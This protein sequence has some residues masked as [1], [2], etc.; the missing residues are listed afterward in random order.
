V[1]VWF[2]SPPQVD[3]SSELFQGLSEVEQVLLTHG[4]S[5][6]K[7]AAGFKEIAVSGDIVTGVVSAH[8]C[9]TGCG[10]PCAV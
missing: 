8:A 7:L 6:G 10:F 5:V 4:D 3:N 9:G 2:A 1:W